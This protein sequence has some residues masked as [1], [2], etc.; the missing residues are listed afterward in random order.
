M[1]LS[2]RAAGAMAAV[3]L[4]NPAAAPPVPYMAR[5]PLPPSPYHHHHQQQVPQQQPGPGNHPATAEPYTAAQQTPAQR[6]HRPLEVDG[7]S[8][9]CSL[10]AAAN[11]RSMVW[12]GWISR[13]NRTLTS[14]RKWG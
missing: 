2:A 9:V 11:L 13:R 7:P 4:M 6:P 14:H 5:Q 8:Q 12:Q 3:R 10:P 1:I